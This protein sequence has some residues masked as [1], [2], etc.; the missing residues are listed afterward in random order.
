MSK[1]KPCPNNSFH[2]VISWGRNKSGTRRFRCL[3]CKKT[4]TWNQGVN[5]SF[6]RFP[7]F[8]KWLKGASIDLLAQISKRDRNTIRS[9]IHWYLKHS[10]KPNPT[11]NSACNL[12]LDATW[13]GRKNCLI[14]YWDTDLKKAQ[15]WRYSQRKEAAWEIVEDLENLK[16]K[17]II[18]SSAT[19]DGSRGIKTAIDCLYPNIPHQRCLVH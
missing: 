18:L 7:W 12:V 17:G 3:I 13:F 5:R 4:F 19:T 16:E 9:A 14:V 11:P 15:W 1:K 6:N 2:P 8:E 10:P